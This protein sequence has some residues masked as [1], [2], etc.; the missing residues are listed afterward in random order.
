MMVCGVAAILLLELCARRSGAPRGVLRATFLDVG[1][2][3]A[4]IVDL[5]DGQALMVDGG[6]L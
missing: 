6:G 4:A 1:Q 5:P 2:G 3:D